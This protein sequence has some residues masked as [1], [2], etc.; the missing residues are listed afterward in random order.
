[1]IYTLRNFELKHLKDMEPP[2][3]FDG[4]TRPYTGISVIEDNGVTLCSFG[5]SPTGEDEYEAWAFFSN[6]WTKHILRLVHIFRSFA[7]I[8]H[9]MYTIKRLFANADFPEAARFLEVVGFKEE[10]DGSFTW[11]RQRY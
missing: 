4:E 7:I 2:V 9:D 3:V 8:A 11:Q 1:M 6:G 10:P 5:M